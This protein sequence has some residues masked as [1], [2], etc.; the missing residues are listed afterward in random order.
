M[1]AI[2]RGQA[3]TAQKRSLVAEIKES[4]R[5]T[6]TNTH[7]I[8]ATALRSAREPISPAASSLTITTKTRRRRHDP[9]PRRQ[10]FRWR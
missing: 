4:L 7:A 3:A 1:S 9:A 5:V 10:R 2:P 6:E 8:V